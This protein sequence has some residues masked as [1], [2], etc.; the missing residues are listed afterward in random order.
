MLPEEH[1]VEILAQSPVLLYPRL[2]KWSLYILM[3]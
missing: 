2:S 1:I 3:V